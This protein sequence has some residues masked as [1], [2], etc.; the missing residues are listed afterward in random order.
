MHTG[1][2]G[3]G[4][5][6]PKPNQVGGDRLYAITHKAGN[7]EVMSSI[8]K[9][10]SIINYS[11][12]GATTY[13]DAP[14]VSQSDVGALNR[15]SSSLPFVISNACITGNYRVAESFAE[16]WQRQ[17][18]GAVM[19]WGSMDSTYW[20][21]DDILEK[22]MYDGIYTDRKS[23]FG[24]ITYHALAELWKAYGGANRSA[25][26]WETYIMFGDP[27]IDLRLK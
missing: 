6:F 18:W 26:Y 27:S 7:Q 10:R 14:R 1:P 11:G 21:E 4:G 20:D 13:W 12:H 9:G 15:A 3:Y 24:E 5:V 17:E 19:F 16:T 2:L 23:T 25:Y 8:I 22:R